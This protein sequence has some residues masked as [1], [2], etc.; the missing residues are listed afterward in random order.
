MGTGQLRG[1][2]SLCLSYSSGLTVRRLAKLG[3]AEHSLHFGAWCRLVF[4]AAVQCGSEV[5]VTFWPVFKETGCRSKTVLG[6]D[7]WLGKTSDT[8][9]T[10]RCSRITHKKGFACVNHGLNLRCSRN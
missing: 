5:L 7:E 4:A 9:S 8:K 1:N 6:H 2:A 3:L 10:E